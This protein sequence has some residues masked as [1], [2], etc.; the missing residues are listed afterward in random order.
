MEV[1]MFA[2]LLLLVAPLLVPAFLSL[3]F[4]APDA[5]LLSASSVARSPA[6][7]IRSA[8]T[9]PAKPA[10]PARALVDARRMSATPEAAHGKAHGACPGRKA[11]PAAA[12]QAA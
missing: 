11:S 3:A 6:Q 10:A 2:K 1:V 5:G 12:R 9:A 4:I 8:A 7:A